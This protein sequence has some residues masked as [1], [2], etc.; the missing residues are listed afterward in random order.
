LRV[1]ARFDGKLTQ[2]QGAETVDRIDDGAVEC[3]L[4]SHPT[5]ALVSGAPGQYPVQI[6]SQ[7]LAHLVCGAI[8][9]GYRNDLIDI[10]VFV[11]KQ[12]VKISFDEDGGFARTRPGSHRH[13]PVKRVRGGCLFGF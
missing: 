10:E 3:A 5:P 7:P 6:F 13:M 9:K 8:G 1:D 4:V 12:D 11:F 2:Q